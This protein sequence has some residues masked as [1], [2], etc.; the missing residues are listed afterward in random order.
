M[1][2][3]LK[4]KKWPGL[5]SILLLL[6]LYVLPVQ[7]A[8]FKK[9]TISSRSVNETAAVKPVKTKGQKTDSRFAAAMAETSLRLLEGTMDQ[10]KSGQNI[11]I[12]PDSILTAMNMTQT[13]ASGKTLSEMVRAF[14]GIS[15]A[16]Y[17][18]YLYT[19][20]NR[21]AGSKLQTYEIANSIWY[22]KGKLRLKKAYLSRAAGYNSAEIYS[23]PFNAKTVKDINNWVY[24]HTH[25]K[26]P[27]IISQLSPS[28]RMVLVNAVWFKGKW[29]EP[30]PGTVKR[31]FTE[32]NGSA[33]T[34]KML[35]SRESSYVTVNGAEG[36]SKRYLGGKTAF[37]G[38]LP[39]EGTAVRDFIRELSGKDLINGYKNRIT[40]NIVVKT[41][42]PQFG[43][44]YS[45]SLV[46]PLQELGIRTAFTG[47]ADFSKMTA[48]RV[49]ID[50]VLHKTHIKVTKD[51]TEAAA[52]TA[53][54]AKATS[55][56]RPDPVTKEVYLDRPFVYA[57]I[58]AETG[59]PLFIGAVYNI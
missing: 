46:R 57:I 24:N 20:H 55:I 51:G 4:H 32:E 37:L 56:L 34:V 12:S 42:M 18:R 5:I 58:D 38:L 45:A 23:S 30:Y 16:K 39:P 14:G 25:G 35:E 43:Y 41:R 26:I 1:K 28:D 10:G 48:S 15:S 8:P 29:E 27:S 59:I 11:L 7:G 54:L 53:V 31:T 47:R 22:R 21:L 50:D 52:A 3:F 36:F 6:T 49:R 13:G 2:Q 44:D 19:L 17:S 33:H 9:K 40:S